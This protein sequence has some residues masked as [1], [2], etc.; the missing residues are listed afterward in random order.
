MGYILI[1][2]YKRTGLYGKQLLLIEKYNFPLPS[3]LP[4]YFKCND[5][6]HAQK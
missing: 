2:T 3:P 1:I 5:V 6:V 4:A